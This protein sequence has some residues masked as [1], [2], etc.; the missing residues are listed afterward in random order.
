MNEVQ[1]EIAA[2]VDSAIR[3]RH[4]IRRFLDKPVARK[5]LEDLLA[6]AA[7]APSGT[8]VQPWKV[9]ALVGEEKARLSAAII[10]KFNAGPIETREFDYYPKEWVEPWIGRRRKVG[11]GLY[12]LLGIGKEDK[13][14]MKQ[15]TARNYLFFDAPVGLIFTMDRKLG[16]GMFI[17][18]G[19]F[20][21]NLMTAARAR[22]LDTCPQAAFADYHQTIREVLGIGDNELVVCGLA[23]GYADP[24]A[25]ENHLVTEREPVSA[26]TSF[27]G[28]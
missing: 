9:Y 19:M 8:N 26:F 20:I 22:G 1:R 12:S 27:R 28:F 16:Q 4:S 23:L 13:A 17:D 14:A 15:Q 24:D 18:Y 5:T 2:H 7:C 6:L 10:D 3:S 11:L 21:G 25:P